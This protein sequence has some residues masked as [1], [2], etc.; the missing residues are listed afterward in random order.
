[1][2]HSSVIDMAVRDIMCSYVY[3]LLGDMLMFYK[4]K[5]KNDRRR[6]RALG[7]LNHACKVFAM[8]VLSRMLSF[9]ERLSDMQAGFRK[10]RGCRDKITVLPLTVRHLPDS[11]QDSLQ[12][13]GD[14]TYIDF[15]AAFDSISHS[16]LLKALNQYE[17]P[18]KY[19]RL[20][21]ATVQS[22]SAF[23]F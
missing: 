13:Q 2:A 18:K 15:S 14:I 5:C 19:C 6:Y 21:K 22:S 20:V 7:L 12:S 10:D 23:T 4:K 8:I 1:M 3:F 17:V 11:A 16:Y 9:T